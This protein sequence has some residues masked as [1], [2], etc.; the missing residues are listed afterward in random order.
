MMEL[1]IDTTVKLK[2]I[3][4]FNEINNYIKESPY[5]AHYDA[6]YKIFKEYPIFWYRYKKL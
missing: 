4:N 2:K 3:Y 6:A 5:G 1:I